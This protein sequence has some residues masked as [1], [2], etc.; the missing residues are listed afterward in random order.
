MTE[1]IPK[2][3]FIVPYRDRENQKNL[4][5]RQM[6][7]ILEDLPSTDYKIYF[8]EQCDERDFNRGAM[9]NIGF[10]TM[11]EKYPND[12]KNITFVFNDVDTMPYKKNLLKYQTNENN[13]KHFFGY[14]FTLGG[15]VSVLGSDFEK[16]MGF[17]NLWTW[18][19]E[20]NSFQGRV[21]SSGI[22]IDRSQF[23][24]ILDKEIIQFTDDIYKKVNK[25]E[26]NRYREN[27]N[28][29]IHTIQSLEYS[30]DEENQTINVT[31]FNIPFQ[32]NPNENKIHDITQNSTPFTYEKKNKKGRF[33]NTLMKMAF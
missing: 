33:S 6:K 12:Y 28:D 11:K 24:N 2:I 14:T 21:I 30:I 9:K 10:L 23:Y 31:N 29:G 4:F 5:L 19:Y 8:S 32:N 15:I 27:T 25:Q 13:V 1:I 18:G 22:N 20:D 3:I 7:Y 17:P 26:F 16:T